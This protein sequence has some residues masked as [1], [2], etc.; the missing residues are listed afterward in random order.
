MDFFSDREAAPGPAPSPEVNA[1]AWCG[2]YAAV[3]R[4]VEDGSLANAY[5]SRC[6]DGGVYAVDQASMNDELASLVPGLDLPLRAREPQPTAAAMDALEVVARRLS[7]PRDGQYHSFFDHRHLRFS[8]PDAAR[9]SFVDDVNDVLRRNGV[10]LRLTSQGRAE[11]TGP[12]VVAAAL[13][14]WDRRTGDDVLDGQLAS[15]RRL[16]LDPDPAQRAE[17]LK[18]LWA[19]WERVK[20]LLDPDKKTGAAALLDRAAPQPGFREVLET[21]AKAITTAGNR[22]SIRHSET[23]QVVATPAQADY[24]FSRLWA[25]IELVVPPQR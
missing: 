8:D 20:T 24:L 2:L 22:F 4:R 25:L 11:R 3:V 14:A 10:A 5:P 19:A 15:A 9:A 23:T 12:A 18:P 13:H 6:P 17:A 21:E 1:G 7:T 16:F